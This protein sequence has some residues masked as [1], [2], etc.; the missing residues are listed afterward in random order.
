MNARSRRRVETGF[1]SLR[2]LMAFALGAWAFWALTTRVKNPDPLALVFSI[3]LIAA[4]SL[5]AVYRV[6]NAIL[7]AGGR[8]VRELEREREGDP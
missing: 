3:L 5:T 7:G 1:R 8:V 6:V 4:P 2:D